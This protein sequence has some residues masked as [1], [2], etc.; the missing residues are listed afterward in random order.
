MQNILYKGL[1]QQKYTKFLNATAMYFEKLTFSVCK[2][3]RYNDRMDVI[4]SRPNS[5]NPG[6][7][8][9]DT[10]WRSPEPVWTLW[11]RNNSLVPAGNRTTI[12]RH[13]AGSLVAIPNTLSR[14]QT[15]QVCRNDNYRI[16]LSTSS[17]SSLFIRGLLLIAPLA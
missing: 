7:S 17:I 2:P 6:K 13:P 11:R 4:V 12:V 10:I 16:I 1:T 9:L 3:R 5:L 14:L 8:A 15:P